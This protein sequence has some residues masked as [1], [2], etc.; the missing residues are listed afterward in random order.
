MKITPTIIVKKVLRGKRVG[1]RI[2]RTLVRIGRLNDKIDE[3]VGKVVN[4]LV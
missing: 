2:Y 4:I 1:R 3:Q